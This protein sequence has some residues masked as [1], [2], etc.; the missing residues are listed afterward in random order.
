MT[1]PEIPTIGLRKFI[2]DLAKRH[3]VVYVRDDTSAL[4]AVIT[5]LSDDDL[6]PDE[7][8][9]LVI[10]LGR[11]NIIDDSTVV[12]LLGRYFDETRDIR[13]V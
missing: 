12:T 11:A 4:A 3:G 13:P 5:R 7:T 9:K 6:T 1:I 10:A 8:E 2:A